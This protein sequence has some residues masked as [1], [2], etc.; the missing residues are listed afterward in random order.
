MTVKEQESTQHQQNVLEAIRKMQQNQQ[1]GNNVVT[2][3]N[4]PAFITLL[5][6]HG[7]FHDILMS[8][9]NIT[10]LQNPLIKIMINTIEFFEKVNYYNFELSKLDHIR[11][12]EGLSMQERSSIMT[13]MKELKNEAESTLSDSDLSNC[14]NALKARYQIN[15]SIDNIES[16]KKITFSTA[17]SIEK[18]D[19]IT[20]DFIREYTKGYISKVLTEEGLQGGEGEEEEGIAD[21][22]NRTADDLLLCNRDIL[23]FSNRSFI[24]LIL[25]SIIDVN[26]KDTNIQFMEQQIKKQMKSRGVDNINITVICMKSGDTICVLEEFNQISSMLLN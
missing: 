6:A 9:Q 7:L 12:Q 22:I 4:K 13:R 15:V 5:N 24:N 16:I 17:S 21:E 18:R 23:D 19:E 8:Q 10:S 25:Y 3:R 2:G 14:Y 11:R 26:D 20:S 1:P